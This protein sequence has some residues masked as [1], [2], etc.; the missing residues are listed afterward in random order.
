MEHADEEGEYEVDE[1]EEGGD[2][3]EEEEED[4]DEED[5]ENGNEQEGDEQA[6]TEDENDEEDD[7]LEKEELNEEEMEEEENEQGDVACDDDADDASFIDDLVVS[8]GDV[9]YPKSKAFF[10][11]QKN[12]N[13]MTLLNLRDNGFS[14]VRYTAQGR[15][16]REYNVMNTKEWNIVKKLI[17]KP[18]P[19]AVWRA[20]HY[21]ASTAEKHSTKKN[22]RKSFA[23]GFT[24][25]SDA[26]LSDYESTV[27]GSA[28]ESD[29]GT[30]TPKKVS[31][32]PRTSTK[33]RL[34]KTDYS[35]GQTENNTRK[36]TASKKNAKKEAEKENSSLT[37][38]APTKKAVGK[39]ASK[40]KDATKLAKTS[41]KEGKGTKTG[42][43]KK[44]ESA[45]A[46][47]YGRTNPSSPGKGKVITLDFDSDDDPLDLDNEEAYAQALAEVKEQSKNENKPLMISVSL[48]FT[49]VSNGYAYYYITFP[50]PGK[51]FLLKEDWYKTNIKICH[52]K[53]KLMAPKLKDDGKW[54]DTIHTYHLRKIEYGDESLYRKTKSG[55][56]IDLVAFVHAVPLNDAESF[57]P[58]LE[59]RIKYFFDVCKKRKTNATGMNVLKFVR[60]LSTGDHSGLGRWALNRADGDEAKAAKQIT[61][62]MDDYYS[63]G[64][65]LQLDVPLNRFMVDY[66]IKQFLTTYIGT[67]CWDDLSEEDKKKCF[68]DYPKKSLPEWN[69]IERERY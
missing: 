35:K 13:Y 45:N 67:T 61:D 11:K 62:D 55:N 65:S 18:T 14:F 16:P 1:E 15:K 64:Y 19:G 43:N 36:M 50:K 10:S 2:D 3:E 53:R 40:G 44:T 37:K 49:C 26:E 9:L 24:T 28:K 31:S 68:R 54:I 23:K 30:L 39:K 46:G 56:T 60:D 47:G 7:E 33:K 57:R 63:S 22:S 59:Y 20:L 42:N 52:K 34:A 25:L 32:K 12:P 21:S 27:A 17:G 38:P 41:S 51:L 4:E 48:P 6:S 29:G 5:E 66:D 58:L 69:T 8:S